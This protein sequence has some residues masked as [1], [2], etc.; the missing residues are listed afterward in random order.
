MQYTLTSKYI[1]SRRPTP[2]FFRVK[3]SQ[4]SSRLPTR[5]APVVFSFFMA[6]LVGFTMSLALTAWNTGGV[7]AFL[8]RALQAYA[9]AWPVAFFSVM[10]MRPVVV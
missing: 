2:A 8:L 5:F 10:L 7:G 3:P 6:S 1:A 4:P 9:V